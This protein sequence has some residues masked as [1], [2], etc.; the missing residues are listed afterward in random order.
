M[1]K[2]KAP[3]SLKC[4]TDI[5][6]VGD[7]FSERM[8]GNYSVIGS[9]LSGEELM[10]LVSR[11]PEIYVGDG[12]IT[13]LVSEANIENSQINK[14]NVINNFLNRILVEP[15]TDLTYQDRVFVT[16]ILHQLGIRDEKHFMEQVQRIKNEINNTEELVSTYWNNL[17][18][19]ETMVSEIREGD[20]SIVEKQEIDAS[21]E[22]LTLHQD[23]MNRLKTGA[24]YQIVQN[25]NQ[26]LSG[27]T[28]ITNEEYGI[29]E[30]NRVTQNILLNSLRN[31]V[32]H[33][34]MPLY[35]KHENIYE[36]ELAGDTVITEETVNESLSSAV[37]LNMIDNLYQSRH[38]TFARG[39][40][41]VFH[42]ESAFYESADN[43][44]QRITNHVE[45]R[46][47][48]A[49]TYNYPEIEEVHPA[50]DV[51]VEQVGDTVTNI[52]RELS[53]INQLN[54]ARNEEY[55][56]NIQRLEQ[57][58]RELPKIVEKKRVMEDSLK[59]LEHPTEY[60]QE[61]RREEA[62]RKTD[63]TR[64]REAVR[65][66]LPEQ[67]RETVRILREYLEH[68]EVFR[69]RSF[70]SENNITQLMTD[71]QRVEMENRVREERETERIIERTAV[72]ELVGETIKEIKK[73]QPEITVEERATE[74]LHLVHKSQESTIDEE[75]IEE[76]VNQN[77]K[78]EQQNERIETIVN[79]NTTETKTIINNTEHHKVYQQNQDVEDA[80]SR[81]IRGQMDEITEKVYNKLSRRLAN[82]KIRRGL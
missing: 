7:A 30:Q 28:V 25:F 37:L 54:L 36:E 42:M 66:I 38:E 2:I 32:R 23:I 10:H 8:K 4:N 75:V 69:E 57:A 46:L 56:T 14:V 15:H 50:A 53:L 6:T 40:D 80:V 33:E 26:S 82:E 74:P 48:F 60:L 64:R 9:G 44:I 31:I 78:I 1:L 43:T 21:S 29:S 24:I 45:Q 35:F 34:E 59:A 47:V 81:G 58:E 73:K 68:P 5:T 17:S 13:N 16:N 77:R 65:K 11:P 55:Q 49:D 61:I 20:T 62:A 72:T 19:L 41:K 63:D 52:N 76:L 22:V 70:V 67:D 51:T 3:I 79:N 27:D 12:G 18:T 71:V 39:G